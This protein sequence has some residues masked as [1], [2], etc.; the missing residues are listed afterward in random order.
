MTNDHTVLEAAKEP[1]DS[2]HIGLV[3]DTNLQTIT[4]G[5]AG[6]TIGKKDSSCDVALDLT[7]LFE[8]DN[9]N[10]LLSLDDDVDK[11]ILVLDK[12]CD[13]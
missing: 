8:N 7:K 3:V 2:G 13:L 9:V 4:L 12:D 5:T 6:N 11:D 1:D 10:D